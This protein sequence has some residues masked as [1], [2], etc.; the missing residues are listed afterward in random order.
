V[1]EVPP[2]V[3]VPPTFVWTREVERAWAAHGIDCVVTP[4]WRYTKR[5]GHGLPAGDEGP[6]LN[7]DGAGGITYLVRTDYFEP[8]RGRDASYALR[9]LDRA[10]AEG[11]PALLENHRDNFIG[12]PSTCQ[13]SLRELDRLYRE[14]LVRHPDLRFLSTWELGRILQARDPEW[15]ITVLPER[16]GFCWARLRHSGRLWK[17]MSLTGL[18]P[19]CG[20]IA[21]LCGVTWAKM[22]SSSGT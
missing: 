18:A 6:L 21:G 7:G 12:D 16:L 9:A 17:W 8:A 19:V 10:A 1:M 5:D 14:A 4:G 11:R 2:K 3:V 15:L 13:S 20:W 22:P